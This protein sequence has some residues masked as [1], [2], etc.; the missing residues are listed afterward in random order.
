MSFLAPL[1]L[2][3][4]AALAVPVLIHLTQRERKVVVAFPS[5]MFLRKIPYESVK[6]R[7]IRDWF[8]LALRAAALAL[9]VAAFARPFVRGSALSAAVGGARDIVLLVDRSYSMGF[10]DSWRRAQR[11]AVQAL[12]DMTPADRASVVFFADTAE[13][14]VRST[15]DRARAV[16][17]IEAAAPGPGATR[18]GPA[19]KLAA[20]LLADS[21]LPRKAAILVS[22]FQRAGWQPDDTLRLPG[23]ATLSVLDIAP[24]DDVN[25]A[26]TPVTLRRAPFQGQDRVQVT[27][28]VLNRG[29]AARQGVAVQLEIDGREVQTLRVDVAAHASATVTFAPVAL[30]SPHTRAAVRLGPEVRDALPRDDVFYFV[31]SPATPVPVLTVVPAGR[32]DSLVYLSRALGIGE[33]PRFEASTQSVEALGAEALGRARLVIVHDANVDEPV[34]TRLMAFVENGGGLLVAAGPRAGW[35]APRRAWLPAALDNPVDRTRGAAAKLSALDYGHVVFEPFR[36]PRSGD[37]T[38]A[39]FYAYRALTVARDATVLARFDTGEPALVERSAGRGRAVVFAS[40]FD[41]AWNDLAL[42]PVFLPFVHQLARHLSNYREQPSWLTVG[43]VLDVAAAEAA[44]GAVGALAG[45]PTRIVL[46]PSGQR[47]ELAL[48]APGVG[49][50]EPGPGAPSSS[51]AHAPAAPSAALELAE[52]GFYEVRG[53]GRGA[54]PLV[55]VAANVSLAES[56]L[57]RIDPQEI[58]TAVTGGGPSGGPDAG[59][60]VPSDEAQELSQRVWWYLLFAGILLLIAESVVAQRVS[61]AVR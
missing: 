4:L 28:G 49:S 42:K 5:L 24:A 57:D 17:A 43:Q 2:L 10:G 55:V 36:R 47:R 59:P 1:F 60:D 35:P 13:L 11:A 54:A 61:R 9:I 26:L 48:S 25:L 53:A 37:F 3:G 40:T 29:A 34:A 27:A 52:Q 50:Q 23:G 31:L 8:L 39:N 38:T 20:S 16:A 33:A 51:P 19:L 12:A 45:S 30:T 15:P 18:F 44:A 58:V 46:T 56:N 22:D 6:R 7:R 41:L 21:T 32:T 14:A